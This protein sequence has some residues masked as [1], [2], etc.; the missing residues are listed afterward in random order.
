L[1][2]LVSM[3]KR[4]KP[5]M[6]PNL[7]NYSVDD[8]ILA[9]EKT[10]LALEQINHQ[11][12]KN[13]PRNTILGQSPRSGSIVTEGA[14][15]SLVVN[16]K[17]G[18]KSIDGLQAF[19]YAGLFRYRLDN[20][21]LRKQIRVEMQTNGLTYELLNNYISP[22]EEIWL[23]IPREEDAVVTLFENDV[24]VKTELFPAR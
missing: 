1:H 19:S 14:P 15:V 18:E 6:M 24:N 7:I 21:Y 20:G 2:L 23:M 10:N 17:P 22:D 5:Y 13:K 11:Y 8:A 16:R 12:K 4:P 9:I 3:G